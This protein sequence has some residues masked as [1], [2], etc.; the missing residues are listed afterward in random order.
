MARNLVHETD[1]GFLWE[2]TNGSRLITAQGTVRTLM[3]TFLT[4][5]SVYDLNDS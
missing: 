5:K 2:L 1:W 3:V 4:L